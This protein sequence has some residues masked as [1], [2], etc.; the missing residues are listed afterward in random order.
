VT[1]NNTGVAEKSNERQRVRV[2]MIGAGDMANEVHYPSLASFDDLEMV[3][4]CDLIPDRLHTIGDKYE[5]EKRYVDYQKMI[6]E[7]T[8]D[9]VYAIGQPHTMY[10]VWMW[11]LEQG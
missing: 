9:A 5:I 7:V 2:A 1:N 10:D 6:E 4:I 3:A 8:P 11:C